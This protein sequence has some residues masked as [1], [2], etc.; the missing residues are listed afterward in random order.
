MFTLVYKLLLGISLFFNNNKEISAIY[1][2]SK[3]DFN[4]KTA[5][6]TKK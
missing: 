5:Y 6:I 4:Y 3:L 1:L 2:T